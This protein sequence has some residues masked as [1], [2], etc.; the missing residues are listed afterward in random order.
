LALGTIAEYGVLKIF[1]EIADRPK[2]CS[3]SN[4]TLKP[5]NQSPC[6]SKSWKYDYACRSRQLRNW[7]DLDDWWKLEATENGQVRRWCLLPVYHP[8]AAIG[9]NRDDGYSQTG[10][11]LTR[12]ICECSQDVCKGSVDEET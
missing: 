4:P 2:V 11:L 10:R 7:L 8:A 1:L 9:R 12:M 5:N 3:H 6:P